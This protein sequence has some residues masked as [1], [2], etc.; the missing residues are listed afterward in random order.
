MTVMTYRPATWLALLG[1]ILLSMA[2]CEKKLPASG[3]RAIVPAD[4]LE[5]QR[6]KMEQMTA[7]LKT[8]L[9]RNPGSH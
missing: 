7:N 3:T 1:A 4:H 5:K 6:A 8:R 2:G 9:A